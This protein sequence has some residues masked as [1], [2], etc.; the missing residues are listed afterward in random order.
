MNSRQLFEQI[1]QAQV[2][3]D[4]DA[5]ADAFASDGRLEL[6]FTRPGVPALRERREDIRAAAKQGWAVT[7]LSFDRVRDAVVHE[8]PDPEFVVAEHLLDVTSTATGRT[9]SY[10]FLVMLRARDGQVA[11]YREYL[12]VTAVAEAT[13]RLPALLDS[14]A[15][16][17]PG[18]PR[19]ALARP[20]TGELPE[21]Y[22]RYQQA[23]L[24]NDADAMADLFATEC[25]LEFP[26]SIPGVPTAR[27]ESQEAVRAWLRSR[28][29][30][31]RIR[32]EEFRNVNQ[33]ATT[34]P[35]LLVVEHDI[36]VTMLATGKPRQVSYVYVLRIRDGRVVHMRD[37]ADPMSVL[38]LSSSP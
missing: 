10:P 1:R 3:R 11:V 8:T 25:V 37:Y 27:Q 16:W 17:Q 35:E 36:A 5:F 7:P 15:G 21:L 18:E 13:E 22:A 4:A 38:A 14:A 23:V 33:Y 28:I 34:D 31:G 24:A 32:F 30:S 26:F 19:A 2:T 12:N 6:P 9:Y 20:A 29:G